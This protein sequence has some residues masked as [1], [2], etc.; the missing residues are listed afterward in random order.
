MDRR[1]FLGGGLAASATAAGGLA[2]M[3]GAGL[4]RAAGP[5]PLSYAARQGFLPNVPLVTHKGEAVRFYDD[6]VQDRIIVLNAAAVEVVREALRGCG[7]THGPLF[8]NRAGK[9]WEVTTMAHMIERACAE[10]R[11]ERWTP[12]QLRHLAATEAVN[13]TGS[14]AAAAALLGHS[15]DSTMIRRY[16]R[17]RLMLAVQ[18]AK[19]VGA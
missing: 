7:Q 15:P 4:A 11:I 10:L 14:E 5:R 17:N 12:Y 8:R 2:S 18:A 3:L 13:R 6:L 16:S 19:A 9:A 1:R